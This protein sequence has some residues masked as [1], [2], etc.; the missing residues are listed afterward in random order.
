MRTIML[1]ARVKSAVEYFPR[2]VVLLLFLMKPLLK[3][4]EL[5]VGQGKEEA[6]GRGEGEGEEGREKGGGAFFIFKFLIKLYK[7]TYLTALKDQ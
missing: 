6:E 3:G 4:K 5:W 7:E 2:A 1:K